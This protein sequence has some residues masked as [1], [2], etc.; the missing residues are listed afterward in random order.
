MVM[1]MTQSP[2]PRPRLA[3]IALAFLA[4]IVLGFLLFFA[5]G[6]DRFGREGIRSSWVS[7]AEFRDW[8]VIFGCWGLVMAT[9][10]V[11][12]ALHDRP[13][14][15]GLQVVVALLVLVGSAPIL[16]R[17]WHESHPVE[18]DPTPVQTYCLPREC[19]G[20]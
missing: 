4:D 15:L 14:I 8:L 7:A 6:M 3:V 11:V 5:I 2:R 16:A 17:G 9:I 18:P 1:A 13:E 12:G 20:G 19:P 10:A